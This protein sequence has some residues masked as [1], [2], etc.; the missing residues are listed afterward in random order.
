MT[1]NQQKQEGTGSLIQIILAVITVV[2]ALGGAMFTNWDKIFPSSSKASLTNSEKTS[3]SSS[4]DVPSG[5]Y[6]ITCPARSVK[7]GTLT[8][9]CEDRQGKLRESSLENFKLCTFGI[10]NNDGQLVCRK[11]R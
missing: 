7:D 6:Q 2:G 1:D 3:S 5:N 4:T 8:A 9:S 11:D 10:E